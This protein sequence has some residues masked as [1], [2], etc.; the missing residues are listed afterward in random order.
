MKQRK[1]MSFFLMLCIVSVSLFILMVQGCKDSDSPAFQGI[2]LQTEYQSVFLNNGQAFF[3]KAELGAD[4]VTLKDVF[5]IKAQVNEETKETKNVLIKR[6][7]EW[8]APDV[9]YINKSNIVLIEP[10]ASDSQ[11]GKLIKEAK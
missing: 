5:Y 10:V 11:L 2:P 4:Y 7:K 6:G 1:L 3:G 9:M 8:H